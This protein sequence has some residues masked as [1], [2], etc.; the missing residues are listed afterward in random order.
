MADV[1]TIKDLE[2]EINALAK[3]DQN[4]KEGK[5]FRD[6]LQNT[7]LKTLKETLEKKT[8]DLDYYDLKKIFSSIDDNAYDLSNIS[9]EKNN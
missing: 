6:F 8:N 2:K 4:D 5:D 3:A 9:I 7:L 1:V